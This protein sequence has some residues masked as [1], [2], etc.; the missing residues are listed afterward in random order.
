[1]NQKNL[2]L[3]ASEVEE[4]KI[5]G[6]QKGINVIRKTQSKPGYYPY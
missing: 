3:E 6:T 4:V 1:M 2:Q 5:F